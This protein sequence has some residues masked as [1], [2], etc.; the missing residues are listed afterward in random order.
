MFILLRFL[1]K[2]KKSNKNFQYQN[3][4]VLRLKAIASISKIT[5]IRSQ[6]TDLFYT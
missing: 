2:I 3:K 5:E 6:V 1:R 4:N